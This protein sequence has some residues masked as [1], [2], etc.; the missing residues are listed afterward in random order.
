[1]IDDLSV[2][3]CDRKKLENIPENTDQFKIKSVRL[4]F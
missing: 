1:M 3:N 4:R 2:E